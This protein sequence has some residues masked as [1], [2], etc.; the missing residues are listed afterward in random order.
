MLTRRM[1]AIIG[2]YHERAL[3]QD[4]RF[5]LAPFPVLGGIHRGPA[6]RFHASATWTRLAYYLEAKYSSRLSSSARSAGN[7]QFFSDATNIYGGPRRGR[8][9]WRVDVAAGYRF[10]AHTQPSSNTVSKTKERIVGPYVR[11]AV[12]RALL[13]GN[14]SAFRASRAKRKPPQTGRRRVLTQREILKRVPRNSGCI[15]VCNARRFASERPVT[16]ES[17]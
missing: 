2:D 16:P 4:I 5:C 8:D 6:R 3:G 9:V 11:D 10:T 14:P 1:T 15:R 13:G 12:H 17:R 7:Q